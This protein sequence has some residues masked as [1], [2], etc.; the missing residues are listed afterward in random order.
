VIVAHLGNRASLCALA[1]RKSVDTTMGLTD[2]R[3]LAEALRA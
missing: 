2:G 1:S 3:C